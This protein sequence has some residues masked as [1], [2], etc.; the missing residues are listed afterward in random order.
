AGA[1]VLDGYARSS[2]PDLRHFDWEKAELCL[3]RAMDLGASGQEVAGKLALARGYV[4]LRQSQRENGR[5]RFLE[6]A[7]YIPQSPDPHLGLARAD[8]L[9]SLPGDPLAELSAAE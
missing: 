4:A 5:E 8:L 2:D 7:R 1:Q 6:A 3:T 9:A